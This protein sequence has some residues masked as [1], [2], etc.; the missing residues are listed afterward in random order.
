MK[1]F[2]FL[3][4]V[5][6]FLSFTFK[7]PAQ[8]DYGAETKQN[9]KSYEGFK[10]GE[11]PS[12][13]TNSNPIIPQEL[14]YALKQA[15]VN[16][17]ITEADRLG[18]ELE[19][20]SGNEIR[21][22]QVQ[23]F[24]KDF[25]SIN[26]PAGA[27][28]NSDWM[29]SDVV[30]SRDSLSPNALYPIRLKYGEDGN[31]YL[32]LNKSAVNGRFGMIE[33]WRTN[34]GGLNWT[35]VNSV[36]S[37]TSYFGDFDML[38]ENKGGTILDSTRIILFYSRSGDTNQAS[39]T[40]RWFS[41]RRDGSA[42]LGGVDL[43]TPSIASRKLTFVS[44]VSDG[45]YYSNATYIGVVCAE[46][47]NV[48]DS[49]KSLR[50]FRSIDWGITWVGAT[51]NTFFDAMGLTYN[52]FPY[53]AAIKPGTTSTN[54][55]VFI[56]VERNFGT[57]TDIRLIKVS[58]N[59]NN[60]FTAG[61]VTSAVSGAHYTDPIIA[62]QQNDRAVFKN[63][64]ITCLKSGTGAY[65]MGGNIRA[66]YHQST[67]GGATWSTDLLLDNRGGVGSPYVASTYVYAD[68]SS[69]ANFEAIFT[70]SDSINV[71][72][73][74]PGNLGIPTYKRNSRTQM[75]Y[76]AVCAIYKSNGQ[77]YSSFAYNT[78]IPFGAIDSTLFNQ[79]NLPTWIGSGENN[80]AG[81]YSLM[82][83]YPNP[84]NPSTKINFSIPEKQFVKIA[85]Y[86]ILGKEIAVLLNEEK[87]AGAY[88]VE[89]N[90]NKLSSGVYFYKLITENYSDTKR[91]ILVK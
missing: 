39:S 18:K 82:Q 1:K 34:N 12:S 57:Y 5:S 75:S 28:F 73:G 80:L 69:T 2:I 76:T 78:A 48:N 70:T 20:V 71:R 85:V 62:I 54:D 88:L 21:K 22:Q 35:F 68:S 29:P 47:S 49:S 19:K 50:M 91:M 33:I 41:V 37:A 65:A 36:N 81:N 16:N 53:S 45:I 44:A 77:K 86:D 17:N 59:P 74:I 79:E 89:F 32:A 83:N 31:M 25:A 30:V 60:S 8:S 40:L 3:L 43:A 90:A 84:F 11:L 46:I 27:P 66:R 14:D 9:V 87:I 4:S 64:I 55:S 67:N 61:V 24:D 42:A 38:V 63:I 10:S 15:L 56:A 23:T 13:V 51:Y 58:F 26:N 72:R 52:D 6:L 7:L